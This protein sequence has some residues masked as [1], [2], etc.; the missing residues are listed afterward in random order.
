MVKEAI[1]A[2]RTAWTLQ[3][4]KRHSDVQE[5]AAI[6]LDAYADR[7]A[8]AA[9]AIR[10]NL[11][12]GLPVVDAD[13]P[14]ARNGWPAVFTP[15]HDKNP[16]AQQFTPDDGLLHLQ[17]ALEVVADDMVTAAGLRELGITP[18]TMRRCIMHL[19]KSTATA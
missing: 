5:D 16:V 3:V 19:A 18:A 14:R 12:A 4:Q 15:R 7:W 10:R 8:Q 11:R 13:L 9:L 2:D 6:W 17:K 1:A